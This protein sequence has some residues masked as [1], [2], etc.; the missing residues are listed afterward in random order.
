MARAKFGPPL[1]HEAYVCRET[2]H[3]HWHSNA[4]DNFEDEVDLGNR[5][6]FRFVDEFL[7]GESRRVREVFG[8]RGA[9]ARFKDLLDQRRMLKQWHEHEQAAQRTALKEWCPMNRLSIDEEP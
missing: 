9:Y 3:V 8:R 6:A 7:P 5:L 1:E 2:G 4:G